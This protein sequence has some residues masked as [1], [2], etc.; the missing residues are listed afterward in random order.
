MVDVYVTTKEAEAGDFTVP[1]I[2]NI[3]KREPLSSVGEKIVKSVW[4]TVWGFFF[5]FLN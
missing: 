2:K 4:R 1:P 5:F 3:T